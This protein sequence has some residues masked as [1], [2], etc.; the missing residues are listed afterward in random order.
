MATMNTIVQLSDAKGTSI[1]LKGTPYES[2]LE[3][4]HQAWAEQRLMNVG[5]ERVGYTYRVNPQQVVY[6]QQLEY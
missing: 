2:V 5:M 6:I 4:F 3:E 1:T